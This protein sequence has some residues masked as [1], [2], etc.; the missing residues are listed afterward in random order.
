MDTRKLFHHLRLATASGR[1]I[2]A[3]RGLVP[4][5]A[6]VNVTF[7]VTNRCQ[8]RCK[9]CLIWKLY[10]DEPQRQADELTLD[11]IERTF[12]SM[13]RTFFF[14]VSGGEPFLRDDLPEIIEAACRYLRPAVVHVPTNAI[15]RPR[16]VAGVEEILAR[17]AKVCPGTVLTLKPSFDGVGEA[18]DEIR[19]VKGNYRKVLGLLEDLEPIRARYDNFEV[20]LGTVVSAYNVHDLDRIAQEAERL[21]VDSYI[22]EL[23]EVRAEMFN[24]GTGITPSA[25]DYASAMEGFKERTERMLRKSHGLSR[26]TLAFRLYY[27]DLVVRILREQRQVLPCY[28]GIT[29]VHLSAYGDVW[30]C[31]ILAYDASFGNVRD[32]GYDFMAV[33]RSARAD[34]VRASIRRGDC[35]CPLANQ[36]YSNM[37]LSPAAMAFVLSKVTGPG[38]WGSDRDARR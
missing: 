24:Q 17:M 12:A 18:H 30:P 3:R 26:I 27:Y 34:E 29:N 22:N 4:P 25:Q 11:E 32:S 33:W 21:G 20:G 31:C 15:A 35:F 37:L 7:S 36:A 6:P 23:A 9:T 38:A 10:L 13:S 5:P 19:G 16:I 2:L 1:A 8:S 28:A 14:N